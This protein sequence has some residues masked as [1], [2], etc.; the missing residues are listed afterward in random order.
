[1]NIKQAVL[2]LTMSLIGMAGSWYSGY[3]YGVT[4]QL[5]VTRQAITQMEDLSKAFKEM[6]EANNSNF[7]GLNTCMTTLQKF[8]PGIVWPG[9]KPGLEKGVE[10]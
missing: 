8:V 4:K 5:A 7:N 3:D 2:P 9:W 6:E 10:K 1:M